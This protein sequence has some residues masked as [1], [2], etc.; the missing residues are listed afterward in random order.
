MSTLS[1]YHLNIS[2]QMGSK[3]NTA[4]STASQK[5]EV[6]VRLTGVK[7]IYQVG[8]KPLHALG[9]VDLSIKMGSFW[10]VMGPSGS[11]KSTLLNLLGCLDRPT[12]GRI[13]LTDTTWRT[14]MTTPSA[15][16]A[17]GTIG[18]IFQSFN[19]I[20]QLTVEENIELP[21]YYLGWEPEHEHRRATELAEMVGLGD[22]LHH[23]P[24]ELS[25][26]AAAAR[27]HCPGAGQRPADSAGRRADRQ[28]RYRHR[29][30]DHGAAGRPERAGQDDHHGDPR[31][32]HRG[33]CH[34]PA[35]YAGRR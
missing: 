19:L 15:N 8:S 30:R 14:L 11:G 35:V 13:L 4:G 32:R 24:T 9:G 2:D 3:Q 10:A 33:L 6:M 20:P 23:R 5:D 31:S 16:C 17:C 28:P 1:T 12:S 21:L 27:G 25:G 26:G 34:A 22:R 7:K 29:Q 18:F